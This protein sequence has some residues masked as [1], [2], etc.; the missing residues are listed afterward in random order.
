[1]QSRVHPIVLIGA[2]ASGKSTVAQ[3]LGNELSWR[4]FSFGAYVRDQARRQ[5]IPFDRGELERLGSSL[6][7]ARGYD[8]FLHDIMETHI[9][10]G[11]FIL[12]GVRHVN[13]LEAVKRRYPSI[14]SVYLDAPPDLRYERWRL[15]EG[16]ADSTA[17]RALFESITQG[18]VERYVYALMNIADHIVDAARPA[19]LVAEEIL[20]FSDSTP[21]LSRTVRGQQPRNKSGATLNVSVDPL[22]KRRIQR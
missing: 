1:L 5:G 6:I 8:T 9:S 22:M 18:E 19:R 11:P 14:V 20:G 3:F 10:T 7:S 17:C 21:E 15:R 13:M 16:F 2:V 4:L 12:E